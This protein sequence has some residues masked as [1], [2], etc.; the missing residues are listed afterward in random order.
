MSQLPETQ[1]NRLPSAWIDR[2]FEK[3]LTR[4]GAKFSEQW[5]GLDPDRL[6]N[7]W[8]EDLFGFTGDEIK[9]GLD[10]CRFKV[11]PPTLPEFMTMC[12]PPSDMRVEWEEARE[13]MRIRLEGKGAD[14][15]SR[16]EV[17]WAA[18][19]IGQFDLNAMSWEQI[20]PR[21][22]K[23][24]AEAKR[25]PV[26]SFCEALP[27]P[28]QQTTTRE[29][30][31]KRLGEITMQTGIKVESKGPSTG[32]AVRLAE[33][34]AGGEDLNAHQKTGW[35]NALGV[36]HETSASDFLRAAQ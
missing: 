4:Y 28:G 36:S 33:R 19:K 3:L 26:P 23:A 16:P 24:L 10:A 6:K 15:W 5:R 14:R 8:A 32:W 9:R 1:S 2:I 7:A 29:E 30:A 20:K 27:A 18:A 17:Y 35:R 13:Q 22:E 25:D 21:W 12:R 34:E 11:W 31:T